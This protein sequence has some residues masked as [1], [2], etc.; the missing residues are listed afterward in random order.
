[1]I[2]LDTHV[3]IW[4]FQGDLK[5]LSHKAIQQIEDNSIGISP[6]VYLEIEYLHEIGRIK[7]S[8]TQILQELSHSIGLQLIEIPFIESIEVSID[9]KWTRDT[10]DRL[11]TATASFYDAILLTKDKNILKNYAKAVWC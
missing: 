1:M 3:V 10:F 9:L 11:I 2:H 4:L 8:A 5:L 6:M 7:H